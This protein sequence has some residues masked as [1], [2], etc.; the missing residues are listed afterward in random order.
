MKYRI[1]AAIVAPA[2]LLVACRS[3]GPRFGA[4]APDAQSNRL[5]NSLTWT[6]TIT[7]Q[8]QAF[9]TVYPTNNV[10]PEMLRAPKDYF[11]LGPGDM[12]E[13]EVMGDNAART[14]VTVG[15]DGKIYY[16]ILP[17]TFVWGLT[18]SETKDALEKGL[19]KFLRSA[20]DMTVT[21]RQANS[22]TAWI[23]GNVQSPGVYPLST[24]LTLLE[25]ITAAGGIIIS[26]GAA[27]GVCDLQR[28]FVMREGKLVPVDFEKMLRNGDLS[29]NIYLQPN[30]FIYLR[31][32][33]TR[34][35]YVLGAVGMPNIVPYSEQLTLVGAILSS[36]GTVPYAHS[37][38]VAIIRGSLSEPRIAQVDFKE[39]IKGKA[40]D[41][42]LQPGDIVY[43]PYVPWRKL[44]MFA[45]GMLDTFVQTIAS[46]EGYKL[47]Y[48]NASPVGPIVPIGPPNVIV[49]PV[50]APPR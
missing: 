23:L 4:R 15:P 13:I 50:V 7:L 39:I 1:L 12:I 42:R 46:Q 10:K 20:P 33:L 36:G 5:G 47:V 28:S 49:P 43:V 11:R 18:L 6:N 2:L 27:D 48:P 40:Q 19:K 17:G 24:P 32:G 25:A 9:S 37:T 3:Y 30:D 29:Q 16:S 34:N 31:S 14:A 41:L 45:E 35:V 26:P 21:L 22:Q 44:A 8:D 38:Q